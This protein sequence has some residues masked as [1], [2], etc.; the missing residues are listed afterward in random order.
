MA[1]LNQ[2]HPN[3]RLTFK[4]SDSSVDFMDLTIF[5]GPQFISTSILDTRLFVKK[6]NR[7]LYLP[8]TSAH[9]LPVKKG[10]IRGELIRIVRASSSFKLYLD[11]RAKFIAHLRVRGYPFRLIKDICQ[12]VTYKQRQH[13]LQERKSGGKKAQIPLVL[14]LP[15]HNRSHAVKPSSAVRQ[16]WRGLEADARLKKLFPRPPLIAYRKGRD[17]RYW[18]TR[19]K[20]HSA[21]GKV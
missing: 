8:F 9:P 16:H 3:I 19:W 4:I 12:S 18:I 14:K 5:K 20:G 17:L 1:G 2:A 13:W 11:D 7:F 6:L 21:G 15:F 10:F